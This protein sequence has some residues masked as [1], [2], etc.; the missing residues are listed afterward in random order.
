VPRIRPIPGALCVLWTLAGC[1]PARPT[2]FP[3][4]HLASVGQTRAEADID[5]CRQTAEAGG[6]PW[7]GQPASDSL[8]HRVF[9]KEYPDPAHRHFVDAC[10]RERGYDPIAWK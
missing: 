8:V 5:E 7:A 2:L 4:D 6:A 10:L 3:N 9:A 1:S